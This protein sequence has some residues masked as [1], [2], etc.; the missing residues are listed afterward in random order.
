ML[1]ADLPA[2]LVVHIASFLTSSQLVA[3]VLTGQGV[4][5]VLGKEV[6]LRL[7][8]QYAL[9]TR[10]LVR[11][12]IMGTSIGRWT[13]TATLRRRIGKRGIIIAAKMIGRDVEAEAFKEAK[14]KETC[15]LA[16][17]ATQAPCAAALAWASEYTAHFSG[18]AMAAGI[19]KRVGGTSHMRGPI[20][21]ALQ[22]ISRVYSSE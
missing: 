19:R 15:P 20:M 21:T 16:R 4:Y 2:E 6:A 5:A 9:L 14:L 10:E 13:Q 18:P 8:D 17:K 22:R 1:L 12:K 7:A 11:R 3:F